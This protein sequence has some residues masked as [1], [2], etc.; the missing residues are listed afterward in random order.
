M[1]NRLTLPARYRLLLMVAAA[2]F[3]LAVPFLVKRNYILGILCRILMYSV[4]AGSLNVINGYSGQFSLGH[5]G[6]FCIGA[7]VEAIL[8]TRFGINFW[9]LIPLAG[10]FAALMGYLVSLPTRKMA[11]IYLSLVTMGFSEIIRLIALNWNRVTNG[12]MG[13]KGIPVPVLFGFKFSNSRFYYYIFLVAAV[14]FLVITNRVIHSRVGRAWM[15]IREDQQ[16]AGSLGVEVSGFKCL[17]FVYGAFWAGI[18]GAL[19]APY[20]QYID[21]SLFSLDEGFSILSMAVLGGMGTLV[22]PF[23]G[24]VVVN[25]LTELLR[26]ISDYRMIAYAVLIIVMM[27]WRPQGLLGDS[28]SSLAKDKHQDGGAMGRKVVEDS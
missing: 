17:N 16:A 10:I 22:G 5:A 21:S 7:Y 13:I 4:L 14:L 18:M 24:A 20:L 26:T 8:S 9:L 6:F 19:Y 2:A 27:W 12:A 11:G 23:A 28:E 15:A 25:T 1:K 3:L